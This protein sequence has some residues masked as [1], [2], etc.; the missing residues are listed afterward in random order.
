MMNDDERYIEDWIGRD[1]NVIEVEAADELAYYIISLVWILDNL[2]LEIVEKRLSRSLS[3]FLFLSAINL[4]KN[5]IKE[6]KYFFYK[7]DN[8]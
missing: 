7:C 4:K 3:L 6:L 8:S 2:R 1:L 5:I